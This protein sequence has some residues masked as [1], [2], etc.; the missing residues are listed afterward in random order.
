MINDLIAVAAL[1]LCIYVL[2]VGVVRIGM[3]GMNT[4]R[5]V[6]QIIY[7]LLVIWAAVNLTY[8]LTGRF[9][10][11][12]VIGLLGSALWFYESRLRWRDKAPDYMKLDQPV[13]A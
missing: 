10:P 6:W 4:H 11:E 13:K 2:C 8:V 12:Q 9:E 7:L 3:M 5:R 1:V